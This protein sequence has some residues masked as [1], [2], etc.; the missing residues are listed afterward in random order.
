MPDKL[1]VHFVC[2]THDDAGWLKT[3]DQYY[4]GSNNGIV[5]RH[6]DPCVY[7]DECWRDDLLAAR[8]KGVGMSAGST[9]GSWGSLQDA[10]RAP[11]N[12][13]VHPVAL[14]FTQDVG[15]QYILDDIMTALAA[16]KDRKFVYAE[17]VRWLGLGPTALRPRMLAGYL[18][19]RCRHVL[20][21]PGRHAP[22]QLDRLGL[23]RASRVQAFFTRWWRQQEDEVQ[24]LVRRLVRTG[25]L[26]FVN[27]GYVQ[28]DEAAAH[29]VAMLDQTTLG[30]R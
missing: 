16:N 13:P 4:W 23:A 19:F 6:R 30:H 3:A 8:R 29:F 14:S 21:M 7:F 5:V 27:G 18:P 15:V 10:G 1:N 26:S 28:H 22:G 11:T 12:T 24:D 20:H 9:S 2:H 25:Q 17:M